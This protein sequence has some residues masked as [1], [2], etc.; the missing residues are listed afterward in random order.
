MQ[1][2]VKRLPWKRIGNLLFLVLVFGLT[3]YSVF[4]GEDLREIFRL[5]DQANVYDI[6]PGILCVFLYIGG[7]AVIL[8]YLLHTQNIRIPFFHCCLFS[9][10][11]F[12][13]SSITPSASGGQPMQVLLMRKD[14]VPVAVSTVVLA[15]V[16]ITYK[17]VL[18]ILGIA[19]L[20]FRPQALMAYL[21]P[22]ES[23][24]MLGLVLNI[25]CVLGLFLMVFDPHVVRLLGTKLLSLLNRIRP[26]RDYE[27]QSRRIDRV[28]EQYQG[29]AVFYRSHKHTIVQVFL[30]TVVQRFSL[31][32][33]TWF[34]YRSFSLSGHSLPL[35]TG[36]QSMVAVAADMLPFPGGMGISEN[37]FLEIFQPIFGEALVIPAMMI[38]RGISY[39][40]QLLICGAMTLAA[41]FWISPKEKQKG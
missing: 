21:E 10:T 32:L 35:I 15:I 27:K 34:T 37:L 28:I 14:G 26:F 4:Y 6:I 1:T 2:S 9:F 36:L 29:A 5:L 23:V 30:I 33:I 3:V 18:V 31:F 24:F 16:T 11:G 13:Y 20:L 8:R 12:F 17:L 19:V 7:E 39:Y 22:V 41:P 25:V 38:S 40:T